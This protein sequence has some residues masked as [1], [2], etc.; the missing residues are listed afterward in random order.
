MKLINFLR[1]L[2]QYLAPQHGLSRLAGY[3]TSCQTPWFKNRLIKWFIKQYGVDMSTALEPD[4]L[5]YP[6]FNQFFTRKLRIDARP[7]VAEPNSIACPVDGC[8]S[9]LGAITRGRIIQAK[10]ADYDIQQLLGG[11]A[12]R[13]APFLGGSFMTI[14]LAPKDYHRVHIPFA[15]TLREMVYVP[16]SLFSVNP[17]TT[18]TVPGLFA[19][20]ERVAMLFDTTAGP[21]AVVMVGAMLVASIHI[22]WEGT[23]TPPKNKAVNHWSYTNQTKHFAKGDELGYFELGSTVVI[24]FGAQ[25]AQWLE[26]LRPEQTVRFGQL[27]GYA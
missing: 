20:N 5:Q 9:Q 12:Q 24:L 2:P 18:E 8:I 4:P 15:A 27:L 16:G 19:R 7:I 11:T 26:T 14:Y 17:L 13:A 6:S 3:L 23:I 22:A 10:G 1:V 25:G 21:M